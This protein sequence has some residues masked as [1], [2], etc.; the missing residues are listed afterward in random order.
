MYNDIGGPTIL[1]LLHHQQRLYANELAQTHQALGMLYRELADIERAFAEREQRA[2]TRKDKKKLQWSRAITKKA[3]ADLE[4]QQAYLDEY[5]AQSE[6]LI[7]SEESSLHQRSILPTSWTSY[8]PP[9][10]F[11]ATSWIPSTASLWSAGPNRMFDTNYQ[12]QGPQYWDLSMIP[13]RAASP[14]APTADSGFHEPVLHDFSPRVSFDANHVYS[15]EIMDASYATG[16]SVAAQSSKRSSISEQD[17]LSPLPDLESPIDVVTAT[18]Q[19]LHMR[20]YSH[21]AIELIENRL[22]VPK[23]LRR[24]HARGQSAGDVPVL[25]NSVSE[26]QEEPIVSPG[27]ASEY[28]GFGYPLEKVASR[29]E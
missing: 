19:R 3:V 28:L 20:R 29:R 27:A 5:L 13:E 26:G 9:T 1:D 2:L 15:H 14:Y 7:A 23:A 12:Q 4:A 24:G 21:S 8:V 10:P 17:E 18:A 16:A 25:E 22:K 6:R 11:S